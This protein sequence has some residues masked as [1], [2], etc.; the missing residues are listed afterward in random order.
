M[1]ITF[2]DAATTD[3]GD[4]DLSGFKALGSF[5]AFDYTDLSQFEAR[6]VETEILIVNKFKVDLEVI[7]KAPNL[8][9]IIVAATGYNNIDLE[10]IKQTDIKLSNVKGYST[11]GVAQHVFAAILSHLNKL[12][13]YESEVKKGRWSLTR[14]FCFYDHTIEELEGKTIGIIGLGEI[15]KRVAR[16]ANSFEMKILS[17]TAYDIP[18]DMVYIEKTSLE[19][20]LSQSDIITLHSPLSELTHKIINEVSLGKMKRNAILVNTGR[21]G[22]IDENALSIHL[23]KNEKFTAILDVLTQEPPSK[24]NLLIGLPNCLITPHIA[25]ASKESRQRLVNRIVENIA[26]YKM[27]TILN[28]IL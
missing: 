20:L 7:K 1:K 28:K 19:L 25:W 18:P 27:G 5:E 10:A 24:E 16:I 2:L 6:L 26:S 21:G 8:K 15:G 12:H 17:N 23:K 4:I 14:D 13:F 9:Y 11:S 22:L 3:F